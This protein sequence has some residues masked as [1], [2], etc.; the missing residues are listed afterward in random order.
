MKRILSFLAYK[1]IAFIGDLSLLS[2]Q[3][4]DLQKLLNFTRHFSQYSIRL[5]SIQNHSSV[6]K[7]LRNLS[8]DPLLINSDNVYLIDVEKLNDSN[9]ILLFT[10]LDTWEDRVL[11][12][13]VSSY[14]ASK[15]HS[16]F[17]SNY[18]KLVSQLIVRK[19]T[20]SNILIC[21]NINLLSIL[22]SWYIYINDSIVKS[23]S[24]SKILLFVAAKFYK[25]KPQIPNPYRV[26]ITGWYG[27]ETAGDKA[28]LQEIVRFYRTKYPKCIISVTSI[29]EDYSSLTNEELGLDLN[30]I[31]IRT[32]KSFDLLDHHSIVFGGG[33]IMDSSF[34]AD[35]SNLFNLFNC[36]NKKTVI[37]GA[38]VGP[39]FKEKSKYYA[40]QLLANTQVAF[41]RDSQSS[42]LSLDFGFK[43]IP[44]SACDPALNYVA[45]WAISNIRN[46]DHKLDAICTMFRSLTAEYSRSDLADHQMLL[47]QQIN[48]LILTLNQDNFSFMPFVMHYHWL[49]TSD[50]TCNNTFF[51]SK[52]LSSNVLLFNKPMR[53]DNLL[54]EMS[55]C[56]FAI[57][58]RY[59]AHIFCIGLGIPFFSLNYT[60][61]G[62]IS[63]LIERYSLSKYSFLIASLDNSTSL[64]TLTQLFYK[65]YSHSAQIKLDL[66]S[67]LRNDLSKLYSLYERLPL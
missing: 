65:A 16:I 46:G 41:F 63:N 12:Y 50:I 8:Y 2:Y 58:M 9:K 29:A 27:T 66:E 57:P 26:L 59:H 17:L 7:Y 20:S 38:G 34:L 1:L 44:H 52:D 39:L 10:P 22:F 60:P 3:A 40:T 33:P 32:L 43:G 51:S 35:I 61:Y 6:A 24:L 45:T 15:S 31:P 55:H 14:L 64:C 19:A 67:G 36:L 48:R 53:L 42:I 28:I 54:L 30:I 25:F 5:V 23:L 49:G 11:A 56:S 21:P 37:F 62:K 13:N 47:L 4:N 18:Y